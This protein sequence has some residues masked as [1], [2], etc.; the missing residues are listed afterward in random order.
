[1]ITLRQF[2]LLFLG[3]GA[4]G[5]C[6]K[7]PPPRSVAE[8]IE[9]P[10]LLEAAVVRCAQNRAESRYE[11]ECVNAREAVKRIEAG[12][13]AERREALEARSEQ[14][15]RALRRTQQAAAEARRRAADADRRRR[16]AEYLAQ[17]G[18]LPPGSD[19]SSTPG[20]RDNAPGAVVSESTSDDEMTY[21]ERS[22]DTLPATDGGNKP[23]IEEARP[24]P[25]PATDG[26]N[27]P[28]IEAR[29]EPRANEGNAPVV[30]AEPPG[31]TDLGSIRD[32]L[33]RRNE[34]DA[35]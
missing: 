34:E 13:E 25:P 7:E 30:E 23:V 16:E 20:E 5:A 1:M 18:E 12:E 2:A 32:E 14:K 17:F 11:A 4:L 28:V 3:L 19:A 31:P 10:I 27:R 6:V 33:R 9:N 8:F 22:V 21:M 24:E 26:G 29:P 35:D 15:R